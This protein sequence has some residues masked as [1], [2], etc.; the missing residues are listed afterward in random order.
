MHQDT[1]Q[2]VMATVI[3]ILHS[4]GTCYE[5]VKKAFPSKLRGAE[6]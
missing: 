5:P 2:F 1:R 4:H 3:F 6:M